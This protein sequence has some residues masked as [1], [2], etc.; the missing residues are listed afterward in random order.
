MLLAN[1][2]P[3][4]DSL[5]MRHL[6]MRSGFPNGG[7]PNPNRATGFIIDARPYYPT[8]TQVVF[9]AAFNGARCGSSDISC[10]PEALRVDLNNDQN[11][12]YS[13]ACNGGSTG[14][15]SRKLRGANSQQT[16]TA[17][18]CADS[19]GWGSCSGMACHIGSHHQ[20]TS[21]DGSWSSN[22]T[23][24]L[25][26]PSNRSNYKGHNWCRS[27]YGG[28]NGVC[29]SQSEQGSNPVFTVWLR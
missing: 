22:Q 11:K 25:H 5:G 24:E 23:A 7:S 9:A 29:C 2:M 18:L 4:S 1:R 8:A 26:V 12:A 10:Y 3:W 17:Y 13:G 6:D 16:Q 19:L 27:C 14:R 28:R 21:N 15:S 20:E